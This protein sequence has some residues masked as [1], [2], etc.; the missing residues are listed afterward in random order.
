[1]LTCK[2]TR[3]WFAYG[4]S[5]SFVVCRVAL[6][7]AK[8]FCDSARMSS[9]Q[10]FARRVLAAFKDAGHYTDDEVKDAG[11]PS[12][13]TM[14]K[15]RKARDGQ[16]MDEPRGDVHRRIDTAA[17]WQIGSSRMLWH[18]GQEPTPGDG[19]DLAEQ[20][21]QSNLPDNAKEHIL[22]RLAADA[23]P[24]TPPAPTTHEDVG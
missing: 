12:S 18:K 4:A 21:R 17:G 11:G 14:T 2:T 19:L 1:M 6:V 5:P 24:P 10:D 13:T 8:D 22:R 20:V 16:E 23:S 15:L 9:Q 3:P 7:F